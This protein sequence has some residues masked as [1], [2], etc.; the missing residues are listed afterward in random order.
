MNTI[1]KNEARILTLDE[2]KKLP[3]ATV[4]YRMYIGTITK[5]EIE[6]NEFP[7]ENLGVSYAFICPAMICES[8]ED[9]YLV[10]GDE[11]GWFDSQY[12]NNL[13]GDQYWDS[14]PTIEQ[15]HQY[16]ITEE[17]YNAL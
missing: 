11:S 12:A 7:A 4:I 6:G 15:V 14:R 1:E 13:D 16:G 2:I 3:P 8:G 10:G 9:G 17:E 5:E